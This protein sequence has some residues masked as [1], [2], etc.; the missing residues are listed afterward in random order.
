M[1]SSALK[2]STATGTATGR[3]L[4][5]WP[6]TVSQ[7]SAKRDVL[8]RQSAESRASQ[9]ECHGVS[10]LGPI[11]SAIQG[12]SHLANHV[13]QS[14]GWFPPEWLPLPSCVPGSAEGLAASETG[15]GGFSEGVHSNN[16]GYPSVW[17]HKAASP[18][19]KELSKPAAFFPCISPNLC[20]FQTKDKKLWSRNLILEITQKH[21]DFII[22]PLPSMKVILEWYG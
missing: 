19:P 18:F 21:L 2:G 15:Q 14:R 16:Q 1:K 9:P 11:C 6:C 20:C 4:T 8:K 13:L 7:R 5:D 22:F 17:K 12:Q 3:E 10:P